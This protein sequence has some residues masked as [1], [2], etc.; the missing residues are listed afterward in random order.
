MSF[1]NSASK[2]IESIIHDYIQQLSTKYS[3]NPE[4]LLAIWEGKTNPS[5]SSPPPPPPPVDPAN[6]TST[7]NQDLSEEALNKISAKELKEMCKAKGLKCS[8]TKPVLIATLIA[9]P[10]E[11]TPPKSSKNTAP[12][13]VIKKITSTLAAVPIRRN[14]FNNYEHPESGLVFDPKTKKVIGKQ[15]QDGEVSTLTPDDIELCKK[16]KFEY[17]L[18]ENLDSNSK[19]EDEQVE[20]LDDEVIDSDDDLSEEELIE[21]ED[22]EE[23]ENEDFEYADED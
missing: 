7:E 6:N 8:G 21:D 2:A 17:T 3:L 18:P 5:S 19:L 4:E 22:E 1:A 11:K 20:E 13:P 14:T 12:P 15:K 9:G 10:V 16:F 23:S